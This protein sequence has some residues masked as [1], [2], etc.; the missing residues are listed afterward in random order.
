MILGRLTHMQAHNLMD[1]IGRDYKKLNYNFSRQQTLTTDHS[2]FV[3]LQGQYAS[4]LLDSS[5]RFYLGGAQTVR[6]YPSSE[7]GGDSGQVLSAE[8]RWRIAPALV[9]STFVDLGRV[10]ALAAAATD[11]DS[12][13]TLRGHGLSIA[14]QSPIGVSTR[15]TW[16]RRDGS[17]PKPT[18]TGLDGDGTLKKDRFW[19]TATLP[20]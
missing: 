1:T 9:L 14:W 8:W 6:A 10:V 16:A 19:I 7:L 20:F 4:Q 17:N 3:S 12:T 15:L 2:L 18:L 5:E 11:Q 13:S